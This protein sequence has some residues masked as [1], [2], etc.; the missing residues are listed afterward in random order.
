MSTDGRINF[1]KDVVEPTDE[2]IQ[3]YFLI[4]NKIYLYWILR[5]NSLYGMIIISEK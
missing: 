2:E 5:V 4:F 3:K 1:T